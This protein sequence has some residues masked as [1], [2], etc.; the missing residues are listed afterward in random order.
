[1]FRWHFTSDFLGLVMNFRVAFSQRSWPYMMS[2]VLP[3]LLDQGQ[4]SVR[5]LAR[6]ARLRVHESN[7]YRFFSEF[8]FNQELFFNTVFQAIVTTFKL[9][10]ILLVVDDT[11]CPKWGHHIFGTGSFFDHVRRPRPGYIWGHNWVV[12]AAIVNLFGVP[13][14]L[15]FWVR[16]Y[17]PKSSCPPNEFKTRLEITEEA[18]RLVKTWTSLPIKLVADGAYNNKSML[19]PLMDLEV[20]FVSR[21]RHDARLRRDPPKRRRRRRGRLPK[22]GPWIPRLPKLA[23]SGRGWE[24][25]LVHIYGKDVHV[26]VK[27]FDAWWPKAGIK[28]RV[29]I[30]RDTQGKRKPCYLSSTDLTQSPNHIIETFSRRWS[31]EQLFSDAKNCLG[32][33]TA[34]VRK[35]KSVVRHGAFAFGF[36]TMVRLWARDWFARHKN[37]PVSFA[38][39]LSCLRSE[40]MA[41]TIFMSQAP[42]PGSRRNAE[43]LAGLLNQQVP[44]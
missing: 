33:D 40:V 22:Y 36:I 32:L 42:K 24:A 7:F 4:R 28:L 10:E 23:R 1:L 25:I 19:R 37:P 18:I 38:R 11:L 26:K 5:S 2:L 21:L 16:L 17:R 12:L 15:P 39:Q 20:P 9:R 8:K 44:A 41:E 43:A 3:W 34:E 31:I 35:A 13:V 30:V 27:T 6:G 14:S 29:V